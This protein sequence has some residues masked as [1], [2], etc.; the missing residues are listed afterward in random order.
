MVLRDGHLKV[1]KSTRIE[2]HYVSLLK[3]EQKKEFNF[4]TKREKNYILKISQLVNLK[5]KLNFYKMCW[6]TASH[7]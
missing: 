1:R 3:N 4:I 6:K 5:K 2:A 7:L